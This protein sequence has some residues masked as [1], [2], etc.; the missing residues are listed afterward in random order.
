MY[1]DASFRNCS[2]DGCGIKRLELDLG[3]PVIRNVRLFDCSQGHCQLGPVVVEDVEV[4]GF[5]NDYDVFIVKGSAFKHVAMRGE[6]GDLLVIPA[7]PTDGRD[8]V[9]KLDAANDSYYGTVDWALDIRE[10]RFTDITL[11]GIPSQLIR[12]DPETQAVVTRAKALEGAWKSVDLSGT[13]W[14]GALERL[15]RSSSPD[16][17]FVA[18]KANRRFKAMLEGLKLLRDIGVAEPD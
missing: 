12:R 17:I 6:I 14:R 18:P 8:D 5:S 15:C 1:G 11:Y 10:G 2:F 4:D 7:S 16:T 9:E 13:Y 3:R